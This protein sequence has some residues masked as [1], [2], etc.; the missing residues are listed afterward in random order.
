MALDVGRCGALGS[1]ATA[2]SWYETHVFSRILERGLGSPGIIALRRE[3]LS[4]ARGR[5]LEIGPGTGQN[6]E[7]YPEGIGELVAVA[8]EPE[9]AALVLERAATAGIDLDYR[10]GDAHRLPF[11]R[12]SFDTAVLTFTL[13]SVAE[14]AVVVAELARVLAPGGQLL[15]AEHIIAPPG[16]GRWAQRLAEPLLTRINLG[17]SLLR[18]PAPVIAGGGFAFESLTEDHVRAMPPLYR[19][20][21][22]GRAVSMRYVT[23]DWPRG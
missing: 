6:L 8:P 10:R 1:S 11:D 20:V 13:C 16:P 2:L 15:F 7:C 23:G 14:P 4:P 21:I 9:P 22:Y 3:V 12:H 18:D 5:V 17:C 19:R